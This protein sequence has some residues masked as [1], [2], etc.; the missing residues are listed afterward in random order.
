MPL[1]VKKKRKRKE[2]KIRT[3]E[4]E[5]RSLFA[6]SPSLIGGQLMGLFYQAHASIKKCQP[7]AKSG[8]WSSSQMTD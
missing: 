3:A 6:I 5:R 7:A 1:G 2:R 8:L 4:W